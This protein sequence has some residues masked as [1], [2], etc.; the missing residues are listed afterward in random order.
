MDPLIRVSTLSSPLFSMLSE[1]ARTRIEPVASSGDPEEGLAA[2]VNDPLWMLGRQWQLGEFQAEDVGTPLRVHVQADFIPQETWT[3]GDAATPVWG[4]SLLEPRIHAEATATSAG[5]RAEALA[6]AGLL[7]ELREHGW[8]AAADAVLDHFPS[9]GAWS[10]LAGLLSGRTAD[11][12]AVVAALESGRELLPR[13]WSRAVPAADRAEATTVVRDWLEEY[14]REVHPAAEEPGAWVGQRLEYEFGVDVGRRK[15][16]AP[17]H[18]GGPIDWYSFEL[19][20]SRTARVASEPL[21]RHVIASPVSFPGM[22]ASRFW[23]MEDGS[24][25]LGA[26]G[27]AP[28][29]LATMVILECALVFG[30]DWLVVPVDSP[31]GGILRVREVVYDTTF[32]EQVRAYDGGVRDTLTDEPWRLYAITRPEASWEGRAS[33]APAAEQL[34]GLLVPPVAPGRTEGEPVEDVVFL[35]DEA[36]NL[37]WAVE[38]RYPGPAGDALSHVAPPPKPHA[39]LEAGVLRYRLRT[40]VPAWWTPYLP[41]TNSYA[42][43][44][45]GR[46]PPLELVQGRIDPVEDTPAAPDGPRGALLGEEALQ[47][48]QSAEVPRE[49]VR[50]QRVPVVGRSGDGRYAVW[51]E[52]RVQV[53]RGETRS[54]LEYDAAQRV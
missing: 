17:A 33:K 39:P 11:A 54:G 10:P 7:A 18:R 6:A 16:H 26:V 47:R 12:E 2:R 35:R 20:G 14:R 44:G 30:G 24:V 48:I 27:A 49:G 3:A 4:E 34:T 1:P 41:T 8:V 40:E 5:G 32:G 51:V 38:A 31:R 53:G 23:E 37:V 13:W 45:R 43:A 25:D 22:P 28:H 52:R 36:A 9:D 19:V 29:Q 50:L 21:V 15:L 42:T 46:Q